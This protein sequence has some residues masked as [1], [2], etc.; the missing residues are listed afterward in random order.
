MPDSAAPATDRAEPP[1]SATVVNPTLPEL[2]RAFV[3]VSLSGFG[4]ALPWARRMIVD[5][6]SWMT[7]RSSTR[8]SRCRNF[9][10]GRIW[11]IFRWCSAPRFGGAAG[12]AV[13]L[14]GLM[15]PPLVIITVLAFLYERFGDIDDARPHPGRHR[16]RR[17]RLVDRRRRQDGGAA[18]H[19]AL[20]LR[21]RWWRS[22]P[23]SASPSC[24]GRCPMCS[25]CWRRSAWRSPGSG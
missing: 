10:P 15:G 22:L 9:C 3:A 1:T 13:A 8:R 20:E 21:R 24:T 2:F 4:G 25:W 7:A 6:G 23:S 14:A 16:R 17:R 11:S 18:V 12:A 5:S 19:Q